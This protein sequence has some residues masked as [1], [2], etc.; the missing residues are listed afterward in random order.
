MSR[1]CVMWRLSV[2]VCVCVSDL[3]EVQWCR[4][5]SQFFMDMRHSTNIMFYNVMCS[6]M[7]LMYTLYT[8]P[9]IIQSEHGSEQMEMKWTLNILSGTF[10]F[11]THTTT[12]ELNS[13]L[14]VKAE[15]KTE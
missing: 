8:P 6:I 3:R 14:C 5:E 1:S 11:H 4:I 15:S 9:A 7:S 10:T 2:K 12:T 13:H